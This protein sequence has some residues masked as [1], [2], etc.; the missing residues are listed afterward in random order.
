MRMR[1]SG[2]TSRELESVTAAQDYETAIATYQLL[3]A[4][5]KADKAWQHY[6]S[7]QVL[8]VRIY[9]P[10]YQIPSI[11]TIICIPFR[12]PLAILHVFPSTALV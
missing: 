3:A 8:R 10:H 12:H 5:L 11:A 7:A 4:D 9:Q 2:R 6:A 1:E